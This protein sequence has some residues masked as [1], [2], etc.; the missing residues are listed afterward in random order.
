[1]VTDLIVE[2]RISRESY[3][4]RLWQM[5]S[6]EEKADINKR[7]QDLTNYLILAHDIKKKVYTVIDPDTGGLYRARV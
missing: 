2:S 6:E 4:S 1:M 7:R 3:S 5:L